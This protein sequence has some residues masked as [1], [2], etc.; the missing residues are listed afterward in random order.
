MIFQ[1]RLSQFSLRNLFRRSFNWILMIRDDNCVTDVRSAFQPR[2]WR[3][4]GP[5]H[6][7]VKMWA[8][9]L[10]ACLSCF[11]SL[12]LL[13]PLG[14]SVCPSV[15]LRL[16]ACFLFYWYY[17][18][19]RKGRHPKSDWAPEG[20]GKKGTQNQAEPRVSSGMEVKRLG[21][22]GWEVERNA[23][24]LKMRCGRLFPAQQNAHQAPGFNQHKQASFKLVCKLEKHEVS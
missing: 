3:N 5:T 16:I 15:C 8:R 17:K 6:L 14:L 1:M 22:G 11:L 2:A 18:E 24:C 12:S 19:G 13:V 10:K 4:D 7:L 23:P 21:G 9:I 20:N